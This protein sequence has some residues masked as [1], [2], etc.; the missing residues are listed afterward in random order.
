[1]T[2]FFRRLRA[3]L[4]YRHFERD[5]AREI[6]THR[7]MK[8]DEL[9][10]DGVAPADARSSAVRAL[11]N[12]TYMREEGRS[13]WIARWLEQAWQDV[14]YAARGLRRQPGFALA[15]VLT[16]GVA[17]GLLT[18][19]FATFSALY[20]RPWG[21][22]QAS[23]VFVVTGTSSTQNR[24]DASFA[25]AAFERLGQSMTT[26][27]VVAGREGLFTLDGGSATSAADVHAQLVSDQFIETLRIPLQMGTGLAGKDRTS[28]VVIS[29]RIWQDKFAGRPDIIGQPLVLSGKT[30][31]VVGVM[32]RSF[33]GLPPARIDAFV[34]LTSWNLWTPGWTSRPDACCVEI[35]GRVRAGYTKGDAH[36][37]LAAVGP[38]ALSSEQR[39]TID[40]ASAAGTSVAD[41]PNHLRRQVASLFYLLFAATTLILALACANVGNLHLARGVRRERELA[42]RLS[43]GAGRPRVVRQLLTESL[44]L[45]L[46]AAA[47]GLGIASLLPAFVLSFDG[48]GSAFALVPD[49]RTYAFVVA[50]AIAAC[51][52]FAVAP[53]LRFS[54]SARL[55]GTGTATGAGRL[56]SVVLGVQVAVAVTLVTAATLLTR[57]VVLT[58][59]SDG[60]FAL[61]EVV[62]GSIVKPPRT[63]DAARNQALFAHLRRGLADRQEFA[64]GLT[65][66][67]PLS[68]RMATIKDPVAGELR[69]IAMTASSFDVLGVPLLSGRA[70]S[71]DEGA[72][73]IVVNR[74]LAA[75]LWPGQQ[76]V[77]RTIDSDVVVGVAGD[78]R[79]VDIARTLPLVFR[80]LNKPPA[81]FVTVRAGSAAEQAF[82]QVLADFDSRLTVKMEPVSDRVIGDLD[83]AIIGASVAGGLGLLA[84]VLLVVG[85]FGVA[86]FIV[87]ERR[88]EIGIRMALGARRIDIRR[89]LVGAARWPLAG[90]LAAGLGMSMLGGF[91]L[92][93]FLI[94]VSPVDPASYALVCGLMLISA[95]VATWLPMRRA[96]RVDPAVTLRSE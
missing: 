10:A 87:E 31:V 13:V 70:F 2:A 96:V 36:A 60:G 45:T 44:T 47:V 35:F 30:F 68:K 51:A 84:L 46:T 21:V 9:E 40:R 50:A 27:D 77:G 56:R 72:H 65:E 26:A 53:S 12:V 90:G 39:L 62:V 8:Q 18:S 32:R 59:T 88:R 16:L 54:R 71:D 43:L 66:H 6:E 80:P 64:F 41:R 61:N 3:R 73:E 58:A 37:E 49:F 38:A 83:N 22:P 57:G 69:A 11:G 55:S 20:L 67:P 4:K 79:L 34:S 76:A 89:T 19:V 14:R 29:Y 23:E 7:A 82:R 93:S 74:A 33:T 42:I 75:Q 52:L 94:D 85:V 63:Y 28:S 78:S 86:A 92:R 24:T 81:L 1:M 48:G 15:S 91:L 95:T 5:L 25:L 17:L